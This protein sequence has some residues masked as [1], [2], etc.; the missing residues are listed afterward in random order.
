MVNEGRII[1][2]RRLSMFQ[3]NKLGEIRFEHIAG[4]GFLHA[5]LEP[6]LGFLV[7][8]R[9]KNLSRSNRAYQ[10]SIVPIN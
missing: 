2:D 6:F 3:T 5:P 8:D 4:F 7:L 10:I 9:W 1:P